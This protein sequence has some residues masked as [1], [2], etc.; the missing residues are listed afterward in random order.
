MRASSTVLLASFLVI[1]VQG[2][3]PTGKLNGHIRASLNNYDNDDH[4]IKTEISQPD[5]VVNHHVASY[6]NDIVQT[7]KNHVDAAAKKFATLSDI[8]KSALSVDLPLAV[9]S[10]QRNTRGNQPSGGGSPG[11]PPGPG[12]RSAGGNIDLAAT[13]Q[14][15]KQALEFLDKYDVELRYD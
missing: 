12:K 6:P 14:L 8:E 15:Y 9:H 13:A 5:V 3:L 11:G 2:Q 4:I 7:L 10:S 1:T